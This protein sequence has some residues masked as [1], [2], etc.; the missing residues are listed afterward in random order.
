[1][2]ADDDDQELITVRVPQRAVTL[3]ATELDVASS[4][5]M[6]KLILYGG[7]ATPAVFFLVA[8]ALLVTGFYQAAA[9][10]LFFATNCFVMSA[11][12]GGLSA[13]MVAV[14]VQRLRAARSRDLL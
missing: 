8:I 7:I 13:I 3:Y 2:T 1:M 11:I 4:P 6:V 12:A 9:D 5:W 10:D 14:G